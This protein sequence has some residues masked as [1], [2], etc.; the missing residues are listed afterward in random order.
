MKE[1]DPNTISQKFNE[2]PEEIRLFLANPFT[3]QQLLD[4]ARAFGAHI[5]QLESY[6]NQIYLFLIG[7]LSPEEFEEGLTKILNL[8]PERLSRIIKTLNNDFFLPLR[9]M[10]EDDK[11]GVYK[12]PENEVSVKKPNMIEKK[13]NQSV[14][15]NT[16]EKNYSLKKTPSSEHDP[17]QEPID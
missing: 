10:Y 11:D 7:L 16:E 15:S 14:L 6:H 8:T 9:L 5:D 3:K 4:V 1:I 12:K 17:Y 2:A 13:L